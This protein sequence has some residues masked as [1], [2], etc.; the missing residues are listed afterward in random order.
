M[1]TRTPAGRGRSPVDGRQPYGTADGQVHRAQRLN[2]FRQ[3][4]AEA[5]RILADADDPAAPPIVV[6]V[7]TIT[8]GALRMT[9]TP[10]PSVNATSTLGGISTRSDE[11]FVGF[12]ERRGHDHRDRP[13]HELD[14]PAQDDRRAGHVFVR[15]HSRR[16]GSMG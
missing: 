9:I 8:D 4:S 14:E 3:L 7:R 12:G 1:L 16:C 10:D 5:V 6:E 15:L 13:V 11:R 2:S